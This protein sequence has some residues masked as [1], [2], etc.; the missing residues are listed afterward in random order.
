MSGGNRME[1]KDDWSDSL[2][3][4]IIFINLVYLI[5]IDINWISKIESYNVE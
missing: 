3:I 2:K 4:L 5:Y 1:G